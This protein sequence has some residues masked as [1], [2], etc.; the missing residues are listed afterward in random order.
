MK[1]YT[2]TGDEGE[3]GLFGGGRVPKDDPRVRAYGDVDEL[4]AAIGLAASLEPPDF[5][6]NVLQSIQRDLFTIGAELATPDPAKQRRPAIGASNVAAL[7]DVID[8]HEAKLEPLKNF[9][10]PGGTPKAAAFHLARTVCRRAERAVVGLSR[11]QKINATIIHYLNRL[12]DLLFVL[13]R[14]VNA[15][16]GRSDVVW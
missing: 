12:S 2:K 6:S 16:A 5:E 13:A 15:Q 11:D 3:T 7:E 8:T 14:S 9:I 10:L 1:I 4:N